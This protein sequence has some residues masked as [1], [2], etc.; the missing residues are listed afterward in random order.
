[1]FGRTITKL[2]Q[3]AAEEETTDNEVMEKLSDL[4]HK[5]E[6]VERK[7]SSTYSLGRDRSAGSKSL[8]PLYDGRRRAKSFSLKNENRSP[9][10]LTMLSDSPCGCWSESSS[11]EESAEDGKG[12]GK[13]VAEEES[14]SSESCSSEDDR[15]GV[16]ESEMSSSSG[17]QVG[18][19]YM[20]S[21]QEKFFGTEVVESIGSPSSSRSMWLKRRRTLSSTT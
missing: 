19:R 1:M 12:K 18:V 2:E 9:T 4:V 6:G 15:G 7:L 17:G 16:S 10:S 14:G 11:T 21:E 3:K 13:A 20:F 5:K 8:L